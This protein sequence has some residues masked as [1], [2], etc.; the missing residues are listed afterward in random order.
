MNIPVRGRDHCHNSRKYV[1]ECRDKAQGSESAKAGLISESKTAGFTR[2]SSGFV[3]CQNLFVH[4][5]LLA[6]LLAIV[7][8]QRQLPTRGVLNKVRRAYLRRIVAGFLPL[9]AMQKE[10][11][12][13]GR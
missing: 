2:D 10:L 12:T 6:I 13:Q 9:S 7:G 5:E 8:H 4:S 3:H 1:N 11:P